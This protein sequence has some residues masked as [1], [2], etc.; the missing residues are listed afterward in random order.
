MSDLY[1]INPA[2][3]TL[4]TSTIRMVDTTVHTQG[5]MAETIVLDL[6]RCMAAAIESDDADAKMVIGVALHTVIGWVVAPGS[7]IKA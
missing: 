4:I 7:V 3:K 2:T 5:Q 1:T 6:C